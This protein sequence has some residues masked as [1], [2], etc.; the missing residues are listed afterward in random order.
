[1]GLTD[2]G[3]GPREGLSRRKAVEGRRTL[4]FKKV[5]IGYQLTKCY[6]Y[7]SSPTRHDSSRCW[8]TARMRRFVKSIDGVEAIAHHCLYSILTLNILPRALMKRTFRI[9]IVLNWATTILGVIV[10][11]ATRNYMPEEILLYRERMIHLG[12]SPFQLI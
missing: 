3:C 8:T 7:T 4:R 12:V 11:V 5:N 10:Y 9:L 6:T 1:M 2:I